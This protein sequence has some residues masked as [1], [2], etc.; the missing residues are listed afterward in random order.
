MKLL[1]KKIYN[2]PFFLNLRNTMGIRK[3]PIYFGNLKKNFYISDNFLWRVD[4]QFITKFIFSDLLNMY[5]DKLNSKITINFFD[6]SSKFIKKLKID[7]S[8]S[9]EFII[10]KDDPSF[11]DFKDYG[12]FQIF[13]KINNFEI[14]ENLSNRCYT[15]FSKNNNNYSF[16][17]G[18][19][20]VQA[21]SLNDEENLS[22]KN[23]VKSSL[24]NNQNYFIQNNFENYDFVE[25]FYL[26]PINK[27][28]SLIIN[29]EVKVDIESQSVYKYIFKSKK[30]IRF[31]SNCCFLRPI[32]FCHKEQYLDVH[33]A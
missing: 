18:N 32:V 2:N 31:K 29:D 26:N 11:K 33:H 25:L 28:I 5:Y 30:I 12:Y 6:K 4:N 9:N 27:N 17:H 13:C 1:I 14:E 8:K 10:N 24:I 19:S 3:N 21:N 16:V 15:G 22:Y 20:Y 23:L 7:P